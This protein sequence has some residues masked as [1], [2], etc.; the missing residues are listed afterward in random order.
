[1]IPLDKAVV[2]RLESHG[3]KFELLAGAATTTYCRKPPQK[4][5]IYAK[6][7]DLGYYRKPA[8]RMLELRGLFHQH[9]RIPEAATRG[10]IA[11]IRGSDF[12]ATVAG[13]SLSYV[14]SSFEE[15]FENDLV[16]MNDV[17]ASCLTD[18]GLESVREVVKAGG[19]LLVLGGPYAFGAGG[20]KDSQLA[21][22]LPIDMGDK[23][24]DM[25]A[26]KPPAVLK[27]ASTARVLKGASFKTEAYCYWFHAVKPRPEAW[28]E[29]TAGD[30]PFL[31]CGR[32]GKVKVVV[33][34]GNVCGDSSK[35]KPGFWE[36]DQ[37]PDILSRVI[38][39]MVFD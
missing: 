22:V 14:P 32:Y 21:D 27:T 16:V 26:A 20:Y 18:F 17:D 7:K 19:N 39:W 10:G 31:I 23:N 1:M 33:V 13:S 5:K 12:T 38:R 25:K 28:V 30:A 24:F 36:T 37:W 29:L 2:A 34:A 11:E 15:M 8:P 3:E 9:F 6:L 4:A 35:A